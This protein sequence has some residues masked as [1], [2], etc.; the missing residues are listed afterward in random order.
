M[1]AEKQ[2]ERW[3]EIGGEEGREGISRMLHTGISFYF[4]SPSGFISSSLCEVILLVAKV[5]KATRAHA[6]TYAQT[7][8]TLASGEI[9]ILQ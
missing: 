4:R 9:Y 6:R 2:Q 1:T 3:S 5:Y 8:H 7:I